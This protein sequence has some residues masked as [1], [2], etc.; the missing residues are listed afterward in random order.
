MFMHNWNGYEGIDTAG[1]GG[2]GKRKK[3]PRV[4][5]RVAPRFSLK[6]MVAILFSTDLEGGG[7]GGGGQTFTFAVATRLI[8]AGFQR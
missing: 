5:T 8:P 2:G 7:G 4:E 3:R 1:E 6:S